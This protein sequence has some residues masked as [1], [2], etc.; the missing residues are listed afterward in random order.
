TPSNP[1][2]DST[3]PGSWPTTGFKKQDQAPAHAVEVGDEGAQDDVEPSPRLTNDSQA[4]HEP[5]DVVPA[6]VKD[7]YSSEAS[8]APD[9]ANADSDG[10]SAPAA[11]MV[12]PQDQE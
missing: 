4:W 7:G 11:E 2:T 8:L 3:N 9:S 10:L 5:T 6:Q 1:Q 12:M